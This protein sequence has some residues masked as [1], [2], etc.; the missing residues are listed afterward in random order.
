MYKTKQEN[1]QDLHANDNIITKTV[2]ISIGMAA[3]LFSAFMPVK[4]FEVLV[5][6]TLT[7]CFLS[8]L[9]VIPA[10]R[11]WF[12]SKFMKPNETDSYKPTGTILSQ[13]R[14]DI[15]KIMEE[16]EN[17]LINQQIGKYSNI[18]QAQS[19]TE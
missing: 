14:I 11:I 13:Q 1:Y 15:I 9:L 10:V 16:Q 4:V 19:A 3:L 7:G 6:I 2:S 18:R 5:T 8:L 12:L 17:H